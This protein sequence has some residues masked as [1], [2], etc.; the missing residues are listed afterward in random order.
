MDNETFFDSISNYYDGMID[1]DSSLRN[2]Q[3]LLS[4]FVVSDMGCAA[5][6]GCG[7]GVD[8]IAISRLGLNVTSFDQSNEMIKQAKLNAGKYNESIE[9]INSPIHKI[10]EHYGKSFDFIISLGNTFANIPVNL[11]SE[12]FRKVRLIL[13]PRGRFLIQILN[14]DLLLQKQERIVNITENAEYLFVRFYD[15]LNEH[16]NF[17]L[18][19]INKD[20]LKENKLLT[21][22]IYP[23][24][25]SLITKSLHNSGFPE[26]ELFGSLKKDPFRIDE[27]KNL[28]VFCQ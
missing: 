23:H 28:I 27:S 22:K 2:K 24:T 3:N 6:L 12:S 26:I 17:N 18:L 11:L 10:P 9:F 21:T 19:Q 25:K 15:Y 14:Y 16:I 13:K 4:S 20:N 1:F 8:S 7:T 5:D